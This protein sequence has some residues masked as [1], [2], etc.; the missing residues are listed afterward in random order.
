[1]IG[2]QQLQAQRATAELAADRQVRIAPALAVTAETGVI[3]TR[4]GTPQITTAGHHIRVGHAR[5]QALLQAGDFTGIG[6][7]RSGGIEVGTR[8][9]ELADITLRTTAGDM[10]LCILRGKFHPAR[11]RLQRLLRTVAPA[12]DIAQRRPCIGVVRAALQHGFQVA[13]GGGVLPVP[14][15]G[16]ATRQQQI[17]VARMLDQQR[18]VA[19]DGLRPLTAGRQFANLQH[20]RGQRIGFGVLRQQ[21]QRACHACEQQPRRQ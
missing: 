5:Q 18:V 8:G 2:T 21:R 3:P 4:T 14:G 16:A 9:G 11:I 19:L 15:I 12:I 10:R 13:F 1:M 7:Q 20:L 6:T 17:T